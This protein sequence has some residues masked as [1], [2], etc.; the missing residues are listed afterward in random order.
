MPVFSLEKKNIVITGACGHLGLEQTKSLVEGGSVVLA[1]CRNS[2]SLEDLAKQN[3]NLVVKKI[4]LRNEKSVE[5]TIRD[6]CGDCGPIDG[7]VNNAYFATKGVNF[8]QSK[9][10]ILEELDSSFVQYWT[11]S[12][13]AIK[14]FE[15]KKGGS[16]VNCGS[17]FGN[18]SPNL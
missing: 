8:Y 12:R 17:L 4:D 11:T 1:L 15:M 5:S 7:L 6:F 13:I 9:K 2:S 16:I 14:Y 18:L 10:Q 3:E